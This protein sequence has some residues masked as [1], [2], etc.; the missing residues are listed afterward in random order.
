LEGNSGAHA[1]RLA[2]F[3]MEGNPKSDSYVR[4]EP[5][6]RAF[7]SIKSG[8]ALREGQSSSIC[9]QKETYR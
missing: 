1:P 9:K 6:E 5:L 4:F 8:Y 2:R 3:A 7:D